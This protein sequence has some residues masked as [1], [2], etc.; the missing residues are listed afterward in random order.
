MSQ[1]IIGDILPYTQ[2]TATA[3]QTV[4]GTNWTANAASDVVVY[5]RSSSATPNDVTQ[6]L[7]YPAAYSVAF[8]G[9]SLQVQVTLVS[10]ATAGDIITI[11]RQTPA[12]RENL[13][14]N[15]NFTPSM[16]NND[17]GILTLVDQQAQLVDQLIGPRYNYSATI[18]DPIDTIL[19][20]LIANETW[21][22]NPTNTGFIGYLLPAAGIAPADQTFVTMTNETAALPNSVS[23][24]GLTNGLVVLDSGLFITRTVVGTT[25][26]IGVANGDGILNNIAISIVDNAVLPGTAGIGIPLGTTAQRVTPSLPS[27]NLRFNSSLAL[28]EYYYAGAWTTISND[29]ALFTL[30]ASHT[31]GQGASLIGLQTAGTVQDLTTPKYI[32]QA[33]D[34]FLPNEFVLTAGSGVTLTPGVNTLTISST[35]LGGTVT[36][37]TA[38]T[39]LT[40]TPNPIVGAGSIALAAIASLTGLVN[41]TGGAAAPAATTLSGWLDA[42]LGSTQ[43]NILYRNA[44]I[45]TVL[46][47]ST[48]GFSLQTGGAAANP[49]WSNTFT[50]S[51]LVTPATLGVQQQALNMNSHLINNVTDPV[52]NQ[53]AATKNYVDQTALTGTSVYAASAATLG[54][55]TQSGAGT[56][57]T[58][59]NAGTQATF[60]LDG[61]NPPVGKNVLIKNT[62][63][64]MTAANEGI[65]TVTSVGSGATNWVLTRA[66]NYDTVSEVNN[67]GLIIVVNGTQAGQAWYNTVTIVTLDTTNF[68][69]AQFGQP[70]T[71]PVSLANGGTNASLTASNGGIVYSTASALAILAGTAT[72]GL[73]LLSGASTTPSWSTKPPITQVNMVT[74][75]STSTYT[76]TAGTKFVFTRITAGGAGGGGVDVTTVNQGA[77]ASGGG[78]GATVEQ[79]YTIAQLGATA[80]VVI[81]AAGAGGVGV[82]GNNGGAGGNSTF[83]PAGAGAVLTANGGAAG[84]NMA[85]QS[86]IGVGN[87]GIGGTASGGQVNSGGGSGTWGVQL[88]S[89]GVGAAAGG[90]GGNSYYGGG[91]K[92]RQNGQDGQAGLANGAGGSGAAGVNDASAWNGGAGVIGICYITEYI[93][94]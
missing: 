5:Q 61:V 38:G 29:T 82:G 45:W 48:A 83:T 44:A 6:I 11:T 19:P 17:F 76:P 25:N 43:G 52:S 31:A 92:G 2:A 89:A 63:T 65:Y 50:S 18:N 80:A 55:V 41:I 20:I 73:A 64:G 49:S 30:L 71:T 59:T 35:G 4:F 74:V 70:L 8:I 39:G 93:S 88:S 78:A 42:A 36:S 54:T 16:L 62:A 60:A 28:I 27:I 34:T 67:T 24:A 32:V 68:T 87:P 22:K 57:A 23:F 26:Q 12:D 90:N 7:A 79:F 75:T 46:A 58:L 53:D 51:T 91:G 33:A 21:A 47:P 10:G 40:A 72:A 81:G 14:S 86:G 15:T 85:K 94:V 3:A 9:G 77:A 37:V 66:T 56:G 13:Y 69:Y 84:Q 1:V